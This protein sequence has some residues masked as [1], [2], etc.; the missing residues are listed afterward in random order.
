MI[1]DDILRERIVGPTMEK[2]GQSI[3][4]AKEKLG[5]WPLYCWVSQS[6]W[7]AMVKEQ[8]GGPWF[9]QMKIYHTPVLPPHLWGSSVV[10]VSS[11]STSTN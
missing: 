2:I 4:R 8:F 11:C 10:G 3:V 1:H 9:G 6:E 5:F 7:D